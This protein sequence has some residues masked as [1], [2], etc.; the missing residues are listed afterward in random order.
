MQDDGATANDG[1]VEAVER[2]VILE[3]HGDIW[4]ERLQRLVDEGYVDD[5][6]LDE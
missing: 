4:T 1:D 6:L 3:A 5:L 2:R